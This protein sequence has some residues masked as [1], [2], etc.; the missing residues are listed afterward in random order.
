MDIAFKKPEPVAFTS[1]SVTQLTGETRRRRA[2][3]DIR[4][5]EH[6][7]NQPQ[8]KGPTI[9]L[10]NRRKL[11]TS[12]HQ[13]PRRACPQWTNGVPP[14]HATQDSATLRSLTKGRSQSLISLSRHTIKPVTP[15]GRLWRSR[16][17]KA[18]SWTDVLP[19]L[20][21]QS[22]GLPKSVPG[23]R[24]DSVLR[25]EAIEKEK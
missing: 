8:R 19:S 14:F 2:R 4:R 17:Q 12:R 16:S 11:N 6:P 7:G 21:S 25:E 18:R 5:T 22:A 24:Q 1:V 10:R 13:A 20:G 9:L 3:K 23:L 15:T